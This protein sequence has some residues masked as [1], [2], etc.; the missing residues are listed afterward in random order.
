[1]PKLISRRRVCVDV[2]V[3]PFCLSLLVVSVVSAEDWAQFRGPSAQ[4]HSKAKGLATKWGTKKNVAWKVAVDGGGWSSPIVSKGR[5]Y[6]TTAVPDPKDPKA[7]PSLRVFAF[8]AKSGKSI[9]DVEVFQQDPKRSGRIHGKNSHASPTPISDGKHVWVHF[10]T[11]GTACLDTDGKIVWKNTELEYKPVHGSG[12]S[13]TLVDGLLIFSCDGAKSPFVV[14]ID[15]KTGKIRWKTPR[16]ESTGKKFAFCTPLV[17][18]KEVF[19][20]GANW[21]SSYDIATGR[22]T[23][24]VWHGGYSVVPR[25]VFGH[26]NIYFSSSFDQASI[27]AVRPGGKDDVTKTHVTWSMKR[28]APHTPSV[29]LVGDELFMVSDK[30]IATCLDAKTGKQHWRKRLGGAY[31]ASPFVA[32]GKIYFQSEEGVGVVIRASTE[33]EEIARNDLEE[34]S[35]ASPAPSGKSIFIRTASHLW[36][37]R[38]GTR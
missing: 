25:P 11:N 17:I 28:S 13:P 23:W 33:F 26:G 1:M 19:L 10:G 37:I 15:A 7:G 14:A 5:V 16:A 8:D 21:A 4:G 20:P 30:G 12:G 35:L 9:W 38:S 27:L 32:N 22:E 24:R 3:V 34:R 2:F 31:S 36:C 18:G 6:L 29:V